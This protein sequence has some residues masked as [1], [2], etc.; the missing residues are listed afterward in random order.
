MNSEPQENIVLVNENVTEQFGPV[1]LV[2][3][4]ILSSVLQTIPVASN[5]ID[6]CLKPLR[7]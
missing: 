2:S 6:L 4:R 1:Y 3:G 7:T 5:T